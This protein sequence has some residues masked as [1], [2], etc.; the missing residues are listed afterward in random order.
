MLCLGLHGFSEQTVMRVA[1]HAAAI[2]MC[3]THARCSL[4][5]ALHLS[6]CMLCH[7]TEEPAVVAGR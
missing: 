3:T 6:F 5:K 7:A 1:V 4:W 2:Y